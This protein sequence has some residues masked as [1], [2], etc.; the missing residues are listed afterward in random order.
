MREELF[1]TVVQVCDIDDCEVS[2]IQFDGMDW[3]GVITGG[4]SYGDAPTDAFESIAII[5]WFPDVW[6]LLKHFAQED[7]KDVGS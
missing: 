4:M 6:D 2:T 5:G 7:Y 3:M 1:D